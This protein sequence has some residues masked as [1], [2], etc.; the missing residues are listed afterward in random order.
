MGVLGSG[1]NRPGGNEA[2]GRAQSQVLSWFQRA[3]QQTPE[4]RSYHRPRRL[5]YGPG[6]P[7]RNDCSF[8]DL[9]NVPVPIRHGSPNLNG[10]GASPSQR[11][12]RFFRELILSS[13]PNVRCTAFPPLVCTENLSS[14]VVVVKSAKDGV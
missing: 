1:K 9:V 6:G 14:A 12:G 7:A 4:R 11:Q 3:Q 2:P 10:L 8:R 5:Q 13:L